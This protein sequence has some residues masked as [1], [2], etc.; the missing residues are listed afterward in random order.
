LAGPALERKPQTS[1]LKLLWI[2]AIL[3]LLGAGA[4]WQVNEFYGTA[5]RQAT[6]TTDGTYSDVSQRWL[7]TRVALFERG[8]PYSPAVVPRIQALYYGHALQGD[9]PHRPRDPQGFFYPLYAIWLFAPLALLPFPLA[10]LVFKGL[11]GLALVG[12]TLAW[13]D[14]L[15]WPAWR[16]ARWAL[17]L[18]GLIT[19]AG[20][21][22]ITSDQPTALIYGLLLG[23]LWAAG[24]GQPGLA[25]VLLALCWIK[26]Q[27]ALLLT[28][29]LA[30][31]ALA[32]PPRRRL[33][34]AF[35]GTLAGLLIASELWQPGWAG[36]WLQTLP[37]RPG[38]LAGISGANGV[39]DWALLALRALPAGV[40][41][42]AWWPPRRR[43]L[44]DRR[45]LFLIAFTLVVT[46]VL[47]QPWYTYN[48][49]LLY[50]PLLG[51]LAG[52]TSAPQGQEAPPPRGLGWISVAV[53]VAPWAI[54]SGLVA[55]YLGG[56]L[57]STG[58]GWPGFAALALLT[59]TLLGGL[60]VLTFL[61]TYLAWAVSRRGRWFEVGGAR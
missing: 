27:L 8:D 12:G 3:A 33:L 4:I 43:P 42:L 6:N 56:G 39:V 41:V 9:D 29:G 37:S 16:A 31:W 58:L 25:G 40:A 60:T 15:G 32:E 49:M 36:A 22:L 46:V 50:P 14:L 59:G 34:L 35:A 52:L 53:W 51:L 61:F 17:A 10:S 47:Q 45:V 20:Q 1:N 55:I 7:G 44:T 13:L 30:V 38:G 21:A 28:A 18:G 26:P 54:Y 19:L 2:A 57:P 23:A 24:R 48:L 11:A 5:F